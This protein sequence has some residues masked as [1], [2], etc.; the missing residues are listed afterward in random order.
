MV[1]MAIAS[2]APDVYTRE[3]ARERMLAYLGNLAVGPRATVGPGTQW[4]PC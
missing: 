1:I 2:R 4:Q 3:G